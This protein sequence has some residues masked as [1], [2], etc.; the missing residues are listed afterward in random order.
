MKKRVTT[1]AL[2]LA[3]VLSMTTV[4]FATDNSFETPID[5]VNQV[6]VNDKYFASLDQAFAYQVEVGAE[7]VALNAD[8]TVGD[9]EVPAGAVLDLNGYTLTANTLDSTAAAAYIID[10]TDGD[11]VFVVGTHEFNENNPQLPIYDAAVGGYRFFKVSV[12]SVA[13]TG[14]TSASPKYWFK[15][16]FDNFEDVYSLIKA[17]SDVDLKVFVNWDG[18]AAVATADSAFVAKWAD[19]YNSNNGI[20]ITTSLVDIEGKANIAAIP[21]VG[22]NGVDMEGATL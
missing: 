7:C 21:A 20:Y 4:A 18:G 11:G 15:V 1:L 6:T 2:V 19:T 9:L 22:A 17:G 3:M 16:V 5:V 10:S 8:L 14:K 12:K 13:V